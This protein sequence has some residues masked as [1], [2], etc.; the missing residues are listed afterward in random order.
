MNKSI[1]IKFLILIAILFFI[2]NSFKKD[3]KIIRPSTNF[4]KEQIVDSQIEKNNEILISGWVPWWE[5][6]KAIESI[7]LNSNKISA[8]SP[9][10]YK[11]N[12]QA[13]LEQIESK[14]KQEVITS[15]V[16]YQIKIIPTISN[17]GQF[18]FDSE[19][20]HK[21]L[22]SKEI[23]QNFINEI[24]QIAVDNDY[25]G[26][27]FDWEEIKAEDKDLYSEFIKSVSIEFDKFDLILSVC[28]HAQTGQLTDWVGTQ[29]QD[30]KKIG[31]YADLVRVMAYDF[32][33][34]GSPPGSI[35]P[36]QTLK[37]VIE[38]NLT[39]IPVEK[40]VIGLPTYGYD[41]K[42]NIGEPLQH[43]RILERINNH[44]I[45]IK[46]DEKT[47]SKWGMYEVNGAKRTIWFEDGESLFE[48]INIITDYN[49]FQICF[50]HLGGEDS[51]IW[52]I[53]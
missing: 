4:Q 51:Q 34:S 42:S 45:E 21:L 32:H 39:K 35:I 12:N 43:Y 47:N 22:N 10:W 11:I 38:H 24:I 31:E 26:W 49:I 3:E 18:G 14:N 2:I 5:E 25:Q 36:I 17:A 1:L 13:R 44:K 40:L 7:K 20:V 53:F 50:W 30:L 16:D 41:W 27:D 33:Y 29:G 8:I 37:K 52:S 15:A 28:V 48:K 46:L 19:R 9:V 6:E 23:Q